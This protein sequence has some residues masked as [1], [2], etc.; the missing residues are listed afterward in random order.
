MSVGRSEIDRELRDRNWPRV[1]RPRIRARGHN[2]PQ[3][4]DE[5]AAVA[6]GREG[7]A[8]LRADVVESSRAR[9]GKVDVQG[10]RAG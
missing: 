2:D 10:V 6:V 3:L 9:K 1:A 4:V 7:V 5:G 8:H